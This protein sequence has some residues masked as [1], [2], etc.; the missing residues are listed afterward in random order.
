MKRI[1][2]NGFKFAGV[3]HTAV[4]LWRHPDNQ[5]YRYTDL[6]YWLETARTLEA[7]K[8]RQPVPG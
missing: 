1:H 6:D 4:G 7:G 5:A 8:I 3:G 2:L